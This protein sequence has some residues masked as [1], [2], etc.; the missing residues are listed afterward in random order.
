[1]LSCPP[2]PRQFDYLERDSRYCGV[3]I[4]CDFN[5]LMQFSK[6]S[7]RCSPLFP[8]GAAPLCFPAAP[9]PAGTRPGSIDGVAQTAL[10]ARQPL[11]P[12]PSAHYPTLAS[13]PP[14]SCPAGDR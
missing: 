10:P 13:H 4:A 7:L 14:L 3:R 11:P 1:M 2:S 5:R 12:P 6:A 8:C 9:S